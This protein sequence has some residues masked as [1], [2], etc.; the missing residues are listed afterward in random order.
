MQKGCIGHVK[1]LLAAAAIILA[2]VTATETPAVELVP[3]KETYT[4][5]C[6]ACHGSGA[7]GAPRLGDAASWAP[8]IAQ[9]VAVMAAHAIA[10]YQGRS[11]YMPARGGFN[12]LTDE[13]VTAAVVYMA[14]ESR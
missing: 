3:G 14:G 8:R 6:A 7:A 4:R 5:N 10:G 11:G 13:E 1:Q 9:G 12:S 2:G